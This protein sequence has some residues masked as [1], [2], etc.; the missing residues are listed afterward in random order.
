MQNFVDAVI[1][2]N[3]INYICGTKDIIK[4]PI[5]IFN[6]EACDFLHELSSTLLKSH[7]SRLYTDLAALAFWCRKANI[8]KIKSNF[9]D[10]EGFM[11]KGL[12]LHIAPSNIPINF[13][14]SFF[15]SLLAGN[16]NIVRLP[17]KKFAQVDFLCS[18]IKSILKK[19]PNLE[20]RN[21]LVSYAKNSDATAYFSKLADARLI[22]G[23]DASIQSIKSIQ[24][25][26]RCLDIAFADRYSICIIDA[27]A[28]LKADNKAMQALGNNFYNDTYLMDQNACSSPQLIYWVNDNNAA[29]EKFWQHIY[30]FAKTKYI[31]QDSIVVDKYTKLCI[32]AINTDMIKGFSKLDNL[33]YRL[34]LNSIN[35]DV[36]EIRGKGG[37]F[38]EYSLKDF[39]E[40]YSIINEKYQTITYF[41][42]DANEIRE[43]I[44]AHNLTGVDRIVPIGKAMDIDVFWDGHDLLRE[45]SRKICVL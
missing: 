11:G 15:F 21:A 22:W 42:I 4:S 31:L 30:E 19:Y 36:H 10:C 32:D 6:A 41:G 13:A 40:L 5:S 12:C 29:R 14:F 9:G 28:I 17:S 34:E 27:D 26:P 1:P 20:S 43:N 23:G 16:A 44:I 33:I 3:K 7:E 39:E 25:K 45:L 35:K 8:Q 18:V 24:A 38:Y 2:M 37:Y